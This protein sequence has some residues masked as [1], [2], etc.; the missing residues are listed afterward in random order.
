[1]DCIKNQPLPNPFASR[2]ISVLGNR[3]LREPQR[4]AHVAIKNHFTNSDLPTM[5]QIPVGCGKT[6]L[7]SI[8]PFGISQKRALI[9]A[10]NVTIREAIF[11]AVDSASRTCFW[12][13]HGVVAG[14]PEGPFAAK[15]DGKDCTMRDCVDSHFVV[16]NI[17]QLV[18]SKGRWL[19]DFPPS[20]FDMIMIDEGHHNAAKSWQR[21][22]ERFPKAKVISLTATPFRADKKELT[23]ELVYRYSFLRAMQRGYIKQLTASHTAPSELAFTFRDEARR[24]GLDE[25]MLLREEAWFSRGVALAPE[26]NRHIVSASIEAC[27]RLRSTTNGNQ[28]IIAA[29]CSVDHADQ[30]AKLYRE[31]GLIAEAIHSGQSKQVQANIIKRLK[32][33]V[34]DVIVQVQMLGEG[35]DHPPLS[36]AAVFRPFRSLPP[37]IQFIGRVMRV[38]RDESGVMDRG[39]VISHVGLNTEQY[40]D[41]FKTLDEEDKQFWTSMLHGGDDGLNSKSDSTE[42]SITSNCEGGTQAESMEVS[43]EN[44]AEHYESNYTEQL[45]AIGE[46]SIGQQQY[47]VE[48]PLYAGPQQRRRES[49]SRLQNSVNDMV[50]NVLRE[51]QMSPSGFNIGRRT[52][53]MRHMGNWAAVRFLAYWRLNEAVNRKG[54]KGAAWTLE[55]TETAIELLPDLKTYLV[56]YVEAKC[57]SNR[58][59]SQ[60]LQRSNWVRKPREGRGH[61]KSKTSH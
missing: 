21:V 48:G 6:G 3:T 15:L 35:F 55:E 43:W 40:W 38:H 14:R 1:M 33:H 52:R 25:I 50:R 39:A 59:T 12:R 19:N 4:L 61:G 58:Q 34:L 26:C 24:V 57:P 60:P 31:Q 9:V 51:L 22:I 42:E 7:M 37:Y 20:F 29:A 47:I 2:E 27:E 13:Q 23:G 41:Q 45:E 10:P 49:R 54:K 44:I 53:M 18:A 5:V 28:Q 46:V 30:I 8:L 17:Q 32:R 16:T 36:V 56:S 11:A